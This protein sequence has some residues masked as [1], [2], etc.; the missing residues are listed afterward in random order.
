MS[1][2]RLCFGSIRPQSPSSIAGAATRLGMG[3]VKLAF[4][5]EVDFAGLLRIG[6]PYEEGLKRSDGSASH[7]LEPAEQ[8]GLP[9][10]CCWHNGQTMR[11]SHA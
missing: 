6:G 4:E 8:L 9:S 5:Q 7:S 2:V 1:L 11:I 10:G 3:P